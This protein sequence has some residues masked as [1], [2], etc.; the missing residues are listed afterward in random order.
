MGPEGS[1]AEFRQA[2]A[3]RLGHAERRAAAAGALGARGGGGR[4]SKWLPAASAR[5]FAPWRREAHQASARGT[6]RGAERVD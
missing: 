3:G 2:G 1:P 4:G 5:H 6:L